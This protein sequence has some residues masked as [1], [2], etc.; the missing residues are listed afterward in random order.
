MLSGTRQ[1]KS[2]TISDDNNSTII[3]IN[4]KDHIIHPTTL[5]SKINNIEDKAMEITNYY[6]NNGELKNWKEGKKLSDKELKERNFDNFKEAMKI[7]NLTID[8]ESLINIYL[9]D[10]TSPSELNNFINTSIDQVIN[11]YTINRVINLWLWNN[12]KILKTHNNFL[13]T[14]YYKL[15]TIYNR[16]LVNDNLKK[17]IKQYIDYWTQNKNENDFN[18]NLYKDLIQHLKKL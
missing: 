3:K 14:I 2:E 7:S 16:E 15:L 10:T 1:I 6:I 9:E 13:E 17:N 12:I 5:S 18:F 11:F 8:S 4:P